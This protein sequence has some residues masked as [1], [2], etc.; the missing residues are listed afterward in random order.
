MK[1]IVAILAL[2]I[3]SVAYADES[4]DA[5]IKKSM[6]KY[7]IKDSIL[8]TYIRDLRVQASGLS[9]YDVSPN[10]DPEN[11][12]LRYEL[13]VPH[14][15]Y[16]GTYKFNGTEHKFK[17]DEKMM[18]VNVEAGL[19]V[20]VNGTLEVTKESS[21]RLTDGQLSGIP[22]QAVKNAV[23]NIHL[24]LKIVYGQVMLRRL[25]RELSKAKY[26]D[27]ASYGTCDMCP[28]VCP[29]WCIIG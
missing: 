10:V 23:K 19:N 16:I 29:I 28:F 14:I 25:S 8:V 6:M 2:A 21:V 5:F 9:H 18:T 20:T 4:L 11:H 27:V 22:N 26:D 17:A 12:S 15:R 7:K 24:G 13:T 1:F 3:L